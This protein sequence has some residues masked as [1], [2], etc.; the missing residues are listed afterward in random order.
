VEI[1]DPEPTDEKHALYQRYLKS[2]HDGQMSGSREEFQSFLYAAPPLTREWVYRAEG[3]LIAVGIADV[4]PHALSAVYF[5]FD[6]DEA[7]RSPGVLNVLFLIEDCRRRGVPFLYLGYY[8]AGSPSMA[9]KAGYRP[10]QVL[11]EDGRWRPGESK[12]AGS[13]AAP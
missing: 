6:P 9:Y 10:N 5:Y 2:R 8:V 4:E 7:A 12:G 3:R 11:G 1:A 13:G